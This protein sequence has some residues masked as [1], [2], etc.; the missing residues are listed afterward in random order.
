[1]S[2]PPDRLYELLPAVYRARDAQL[3]QPLRALLRV[4]DE[5][6]ERLEDDIGRLQDNWFIET[7][8]DWVVPYIGDLIGHQPAGVPRLPTDPRR[9]ARITRLIAPRRD[10]AN[11]LGFRR[12]KGTLALLETLAH[13]VAGWPARA[14]ECYTLLGW[15]QHV[16][17]LRP[18][19]GATADLR[20]GDAL[21][22]LDG[23]FERI[24][25][26]VDVR[27]IGSPR[28]SGVH[29]L[30]E[31]AVF[32]WRRRA[33][34]ITHASAHCVKSQG[35][36]CY[37]VNALG[38]DTALHVRP[39]P[40]SDPSD[41][42]GE[43]NLPVPIRRRALEER[44]REHP[45]KAHA[46]AAY[47]GPD[48]SLT[49]WA[50]DWPV[51]GAPQPI[52]RE[53]IVPA[54]LSGWKY[55]AR[56]G[57]VAVD[58]VRG[59]MV[60]PAGQ[61]PR[62]GVR[63]TYHYGFSADMGGG[64]YPRTVAQP[65]DSARYTVSKDHPDAYDHGTIGAALAAW[66]RE[67]RD[68]GPEPGDDA[69][70]AEWRARR[71]RLRAAVIE[72]H[73]SA[74][75]GESLV[76]ALEAGESLTV[77]AASRHR[78]LLWIPDY[79]TSGADALAVAGK[80]GSRFSLDGLVVAGRG[81]Q[82]RGPDLG[83]PYAAADGDLC[84]LHIRHC[85]LVP[86]WALEENCDPTRPNEPSLELLNTGASVRIEH[87]IV[88]SIYVVAD[89]VRTDPVCIEICDSIVDATSNDRVAVGAPNLPFAFARLTIRR[90]TVFGGVFAHSVPLAEH[91][92]FMGELGVAR[93]Q[94]GCVRFSYVTPGSR[95]PRRH[96]CQP[97]GVRQAVETIQP[98]L[99]AD[100]AQLRKD[101]ETT[102]V[103]PAFGSQ[104]YG[105]AAYAQLAI[106][107]PE[108]IGRGADDE[109]EM[110]AFHDLYQ[111]QREA[112]L[113]ARLDEFTPAGMEAGIRFVS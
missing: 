13:D 6:V 40:E 12:R 104:R 22:L 68:L 5:Q 88:G 2:R 109:S 92:L 90:T 94:I 84:D 16:K 34:S 29:N 53:R 66:R 39:L 42:A 89:E 43:A 48:R 54:D 35:Q 1:M 60:F 64:E 93:R 75:Y 71:E 106:P 87:S 4:V 95:T 57:E 103:R 72:I 55:R 82:V 31:V 97:D 65:R 91:T 10:V 7:C 96:R 21:D 111:P 9:A 81:I 61:V 52:P 107:G 70:K 102:R 25:H 79:M 11:T 98:R 37:T 20:D 41:I 45:V 59:R 28:S 32:V 24:A 77:R 99:P 14:V 113:R 110:G 3:G 18:G 8:E 58:P 38:H 86:G 50:P 63:V 80:A 56:R 44:T 76:V 100:E 112:A 19:R 83:D 51:K 47:Y 74:V 73:D 33:Y 62:R 108:E 105:H 46:S 36:H 78:P 27:R 30:P 26:T 17:H 85:T 49:I 67:Q 15:L 101:R 23:P 69:A